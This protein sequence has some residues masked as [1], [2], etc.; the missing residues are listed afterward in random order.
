MI[1]FESLNRAY[2]RD[3]FYSLQLEVGDRCHQGCIYCYM[4]ALSEIRNQLTGDI[5]TD[6]LY[7][8]RD[9]GISAIEWLGGE[10]L[11]RPGIFK[12]MEK[13][14]ELGLRNNMWT[15][16]LPF[17][18]KGIIERTVELCQHG[19]ISIH[20]STLDTS[21]YSLMHPDRPVR[22]IDTILEGVE[23]ALKSGYPPGQLINSVTFTGLQTAEDMIR[24]MEFFYENY[25]ILTSI[26][27]YHTY[28]RPGISDKQLKRFIPRPEEV[29]KVYNSY[30]KLTGSGKL[31]MNC[32][33]KQYCS[34]TLA[35]LNNGFVTPC[36]TIRE[37]NDH[38]NV[39]QKG[40]DRIVEDNREYLTFGL[41]KNMENLPGA[42]RQCNMNSECWGCRSRSYAAGSGIYGQDPRCF[43]AGVN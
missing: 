37:E 34:A 40:L 1:D 11:I 42:C 29:S 22:D 18:D 15:G 6:I 2:Q 13:A 31:P 41:F 12:F 5:I 33:N 17:S 23:H 24:T 36:A 4:N 26:N 43:R 7:W 8:S 28:M 30:R 21:L 9:I 27:V 3:G 32:V 35:V 38:M 14:G 10:P 16:G 39:K 25:N 19:L 20:L